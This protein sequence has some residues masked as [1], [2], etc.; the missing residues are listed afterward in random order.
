[1]KRKAEIIT[2]YSEM[3]EMHDGDRSTAGRVQGSADAE[4]KKQKDRKRRQR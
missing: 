3:K 4:I 2:E 1:M